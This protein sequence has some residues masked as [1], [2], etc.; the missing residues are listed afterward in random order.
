MEWVPPLSLP[1]IKFSNYHPHDDATQHGP[2]V[3]SRY[4]YRYYYS[5]FLK[6][7]APRVTLDRGTDGDGPAAPPYGGFWQSGPLGIIRE[8]AERWTICHGGNWQKLETHNN[9]LFCGRAGAVVNVLMR[10]RR[11]Q[12]GKEETLVFFNHPSA[13][14]VYGLWWAAEQEK[15]TRPAADVELIMD[16]I[17]LFFFLFSCEYELFI[18]ILFILYFFHPIT[19]REVSFS[20][21]FNGKQLLH[22][23][24]SGH[25]LVYEIYI[26]M[27]RVGYGKPPSSGW[28]L[29]PKVR[30]TPRTTLKDSAAATAAAVAFPSGSTP[31]LTLPNKQK[32]PVSIPLLF[33]NLSTLLTPKRRQIVIPCTYRSQVVVSIFVGDL[34]C[35]FRIYV[36]LEAHQEG[37]GEHVAWWRSGRCA[38]LGHRQH[39]QRRQTQPSHWHRTTLWTHSTIKY[40]SPTLL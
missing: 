17:I 6:I 15:G 11:A 4:N 33:I 8:R 36:P 3:D 38:R 39:N 16:D 31:N 13:A 14:A 34:V 37:A 22:G 27:V 10:C 30:S 7:T 2:A 18:L 23:E 20:I 5:V 21:Y 35:V 26:R 9:H 28:V 40:L 1:Q 29:K 25:T 12:I 24:W 32:G 19:E